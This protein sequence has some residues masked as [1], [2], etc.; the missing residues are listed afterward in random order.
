M[1]G[2]G[3]GNKA[4]DE[5]AQTLVTE[6]TKRFPVARQSE[7]GTSKLKPAQ[8]LGKAVGDL[9]RRVTKFSGENKLGVYGKARLLN[10]V[11]WQLNDLGYSKDF[12]DATIAT[13]AQCIGRT[14]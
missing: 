14:R 9:E 2:L 10:A 3:K 4:I 12:V 8:Q 7:L 5:F 11:K 13:M 1:F 6:L